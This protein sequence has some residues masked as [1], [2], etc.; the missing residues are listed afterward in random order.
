METLLVKARGTGANRSEPGRKKLKDSTGFNPATKRPIADVLSGGE[1]P[2]RARASRFGKG[3][4]VS[5]CHRAAAPSSMQIGRTFHAGHSCSN[6]SCGCGV[7]IMLPHLP[8]RR[9]PPPVIQNIWF[10]GIKWD[11]WPV[12]GGVTQPPSGPCGG[13]VTTTPFLYLSRCLIAVGPL[14]ACCGCLWPFTSVLAFP[15]HKTFNCFRRSLSA[16]FPVIPCFSPQQIS[17]T[18]TPGVQLIPTSAELKE[19]K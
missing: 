13:L 7:P 5:A 16:F 3:P 11:A 18:I 15:Q 17:P 14:W 8:V 6:Q 19:R 2:R 4:K 9:K 12:Q 1:Q 10:D